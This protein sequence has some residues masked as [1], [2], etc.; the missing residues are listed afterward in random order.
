M[1]LHNEYLVE[2]LKTEVVGP[3]LES[4]HF[5]SVGK[6]ATFFEKVAAD[7]G[8]EVR[9][10]DNNILTYFRDG[11]AIGLTKAQ[12][13]STVSL[14]SDLACR[15]K[16]LSKK[17]LQEG[18]V[19]IPQ[20]E[21]FAEDEF[22]RAR[23]FVGDFSTP[24]AI[25]P[26]DGRNGRGITIGVDSVQA[27]KTGWAKALKFSPRKR[28]IIEEYIQGI[29]LRV[30]IIDGE[31]VAGLS[32][33]LP[34]VV[35]DGQSDLTALIAQF[36]QMRKLNA[37]T[38]ESV[39]QPDWGW[40]K[41]RGIDE[42]SILP[43]GEILILNNIS[44]LVAGGVSMNVTTKMSQGIISAAKKVFAAVPGATVLGTDMYVPS[45]DCV[46]EDVVLLEINAR[47]ALTMH[48]YPTFGDPVD[49]HPAMLDH[50]ERS[51]RAAHSAS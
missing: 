50:I 28:I 11:Q 29:D 23:K 14:L 46:E 34:F 37:F 26:L 39:V 49:L 16:H 4:N 22:A 12:M 1:A 47:P 5:E 41:S 30:V 13:S 17:I 20:G 42:N 15:D 3:K 43:S 32:R 10:L 31:V 48:L 2:F 19:R 33:I 7:K 18:G 45:L 21:S 9:H 27:L 25:K 51:Y 35:G 8:L 36:A 24:M 38:A 44:N 40:L 6:S